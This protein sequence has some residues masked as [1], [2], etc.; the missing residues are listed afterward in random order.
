MVEVVVAC[1]ERFSI[2][3]PDEAL[4]QMTTVGAAVDY[5]RAGGAA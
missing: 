4:E 1:E 3:I 5:I 2:R